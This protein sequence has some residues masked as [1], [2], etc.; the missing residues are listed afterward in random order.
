[1]NYR[2]LFEDSKPLLIS[3]IKPV[4]KKIYT[5]KTIFTFAVI[6]SIFVLIW[7]ISYTF[8]GNKNSVNKILLSRENTLNEEIIKINNDNN[9]LEAEILL[10]KDKLKSL[11]KEKEDKKLAKIATLSTG[12]TLKGNGIEIILNDNTSQYAPEQAASNI[13]H[14]TD[15][16]KIVNFL[17]EENAQGISINNERITPKTSITCIGATILVNDKRI[18]AP[19]NIKAIGKNLSKSMVELSGVVLSLKLRGIELDVKEKNEI[20]LQAGNLLIEE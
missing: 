18:A 9:M 1:M 3:D 8:I 15:L 7:G 13:V 16:L 20:I 19:F 17:W 5:D 6:F 11:T 2:K 12:T 10:L 14:N 4:L